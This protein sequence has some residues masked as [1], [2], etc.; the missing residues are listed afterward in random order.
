MSPP[1]EN[2]S[3]GSALLF[4]GQHLFSYH[5]ETVWDPKK[6]REGS[7]T[8]RTQEEHEAVTMANKRANIKKLSDASLGKF[9]ADQSRVAYLAPWRMKLPA[10]SRG[11]IRLCWFISGFKMYI[12]SVK[13]VY[14]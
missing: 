5:W 10:G 12:V 8:P 11:A 3:H 13:N 1:N 9:D 6:P 4:E 14:S 7:A 2:H